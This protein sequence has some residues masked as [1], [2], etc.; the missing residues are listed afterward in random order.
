MRGTKFIRIAFFISVLLTCASDLHAT[1]WEWRSNAI[2]NQVFE[3]RDGA[4]AATR[5]IGGK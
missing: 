4:E 1:P 3:T 5:A 2:P